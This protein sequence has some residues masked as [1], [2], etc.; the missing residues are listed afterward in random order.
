MALQVTIQ[1]R[2][3]PSHFLQALPDDLV[4]ALRVRLSPFS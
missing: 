1:I 2:F 4:G 3:R